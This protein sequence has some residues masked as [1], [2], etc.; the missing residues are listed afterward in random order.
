MSSSAPSAADSVES[1]STITSSSEE[2]SFCDDDDDDDFDAFEFLTKQ[3][4]YSRSGE[5]SEVWFTDEEAKNAGMPTPEQWK[6]ISSKE[7]PCTVTMNKVDI[8]QWKILKDDLIH[9]KNKMRELFG[10]KEDEQNKERGIFE[11]VFGSLSSIVAKFF[12]NEIGLSHVD[13][14]KFLQ[15]YMIQFAYFLSSEALFSKDSLIQCPEISKKEYDQIWKTIATKKR[16]SNVHFS[17]NRREDPLWMIFETEVNNF[18]RSLSFQGREG[19]LSLS[20]DDD[21]IHLEQKNERSAD[22]FHLK[23]QK[24]VRANRNGIT[25]HTCVS[26]A[27]LIPMAIAFERKEDTTLECYE[28][29]MRSL[30]RIDGRYASIRSGSLKNVIVNH[31]RA[32]TAMAF[33]FKYLLPN[34]ALP[35]G[36]TVR[37][38]NQ[39]PFTYDQR[40]SS[41]DKR[42]M[43]ESSG[44]P[45]L[46]LKEYKNNLNQRIFAIAFRTGTGKVVTC[47]S[48]IHGKH[49]WEGK[50]L[51]PNDLEKYEADPKSL[52]KLFFQRQ[53]DIIPNKDEIELE[54]D[55]LDE[56]LDTTI[57]PI[58]LVQGTAD[59]HYHRKFSLTSS[60][61]NHSFKISLPNYQY[62]SHWKMIETYC[63]GQSSSD[64]PESD[65]DHSFASAEGPEEPFDVASY[66]RYF[67]SLNPEDE[68]YAVIEEVKNILNEDK[69]YS[70]HDA[71]VFYEGLANDTR[72]K[73]QA[74]VSSYV[75]NDSHR[76]SFKKRDFISW[77]QKK[78]IYRMYMGFS[79]DGLL[80]L[81]REKGLNLGRFSYD[82]AIQLL[83]DQGNTLP[84]QPV[85][86]LNNIENAATKL[87]LE[88]SFM[89]HEKGT[90]REYCKDGHRL[91]API[92]RKW[93]NKTKSD[94]S[95]LLNGARIMGVYTAGL[96]AR[97]R[98][99]HAKD[100]IDFILCVELCDREAVPWG[101]EIK[102]RQKLSSANEEYNFAIDVG[103]HARINSTEV[104]NY[105]KDEGERWQVA[106]HAYVYDLATVLFIV[107][108]GQG[109]IIRSLIV[110][111]SREFRESFGIVLFDIR[112]LALDWIYLPLEQALC[113][114]E[115]GKKIKPIVVRIPD[116]VFA[117]ARTIDRIGG[118]ETFQGT[119]NLW[120]SLSI[121]ELPHPS[122]RRLIPS[123]CAHWNLTKGGSDVTTKMMD[124]RKVKIPK[125]HVNMES[126]AVE[127]LLSL[128][129]ATSHRLL[130]VATDKTEKKSILHYRNAANKRFSL[131]KTCLLFH[132]FAGEMIEKLSAL[133]AQEQCEPL[134]P[135]RNTSQNARNQ[136]S[137]KK[138]L[139]IIPKEPTFIPA[140]NSMFHTPSR[141]KT[142][143]D[144]GTAPQALVDCMSKCPGIPMEHLSSNHTR[145]RCARCGNLTRVR[146]L[147]CHQFL[148]FSKAIPRTCQDISKIKNLDLYKVTVTRERKGM[149]EYTFQKTCFHYAHEDRWKELVENG[150]VEFI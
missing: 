52:V 47:I 143:L 86:N 55:V 44:A 23:Y 126:T 48:S 90:E 117:I 87:I 12:I 67:Q 141:L 119:V 59:W 123:V 79:K 101:V 102:S 111:F 3:E 11:Y 56:L 69:V 120:F 142:K 14:L 53:D 19:T 94:D 46:H 74:L 7:N 22:L 72:K 133:P 71:N 30:T 41:S 140:S 70:L 105:I 116:H 60:Q 6:D 77:L 80:H 134:H 138:I 93:L 24:H 33:V 135:N 115:D 38:M 62:S 8:Y 149:L 121:L 40:H 31:D 27:S 4:V 68:S 92:M 16:L 35:E 58:T 132:K 61:A 103:F 95:I 54:N 85:V 97:K 144:K 18:L 125:A 136:P 106:Q 137:R 112:T 124:S 91:E 42:T 89:K 127:R 109:E 118:D 63:T 88:K 147:G 36:T 73:I 2:E 83:V 98:A 17:T 20:V 84:M 107:G 43:V 21:K 15:C 9:T 10:L 34:G 146:C 139:G 130:Q 78:N 29:M 1:S 150:T 114:R 99:M 113:Q 49:S 82:S 122:F 66:V 128:I 51:K 65:L 64:A 104:C 96:A 100:S 75:Q 131:Q 25:A 148:C 145:A 81:I 13:Y 50:V 32:Y 45:T 110:D 37:A 108:D 76:L 57:H 39:W 28:R 5:L 129:V 26:S